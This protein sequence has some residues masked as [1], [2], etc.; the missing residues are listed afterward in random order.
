M[1]SI[2]CASFPVKKKTNSKLK[3]KSYRFAKK[4]HT[5]GGAVFFHFNYKK[6]DNMNA[7]SPTLRSF[8][9]TSYFRV[10]PF[11]EEDP[12]MS[13]VVIKKKKRNDSY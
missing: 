8:H 6:K 7:Q 1:F 3:S 13:P 5:N 10:V 11:S 12:A 2:W 4:K 9:G